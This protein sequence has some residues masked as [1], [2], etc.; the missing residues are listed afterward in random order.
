M[1]NLDPKD[2]PFLLSEEG[3]GAIDWDMLRQKYTGRNH[4][5]FN[6]QNYGGQRGAR[7]YNGWDIPDMLLDPSVKYRVFKGDEYLPEILDKGLITGGWNVGAGKPA[8]VFFG[9][10]TPLWSY[11]STPN[12]RYLIATLGT[13]WGD[14]HGNSPTN[15]ESET[16]KITRGN[17]N[18]DENDFGPG[19]IEI[20]KFTLPSHS[21]P[22]TPEIL[23]KLKEKIQFDGKMES[24]LGSGLADVLSDWS[25]GYK[26]TY[27]DTDSQFNAL[28]A[29]HNHVGTVPNHRLKKSWA[30]VD[31]T[32]Q[33]TLAEIDDI[34]KQ[35]EE[36]LKTR[37]GIDAS[38]DRTD[39]RR[40]I[41]KNQELLFDEMLDAYSSP[42]FFQSRIGFKDLIRQ[43]LM[44]MD[45]I[46]RQKVFVDLFTPE[47]RD[48][49]IDHAAWVDNSMAFLQKA[50]KDPN[51][52]ESLK[53]LI[54]KNNRWTSDGVLGALKMAEE[55]MPNFFD[56]AFWTGRSNSTAANRIPWN[57]T[58]SAEGMRLFLTAVD[59]AIKSGK[60]NPYSGSIL[61]NFLKADL[62]QITYGAKSNHWLGPGTTS[63]YTYFPS[64]EETSRLPFFPMS[65]QTVSTA[66]DSNSNFT[67]KEFFE[68]PT[69]KRYLKGPGGF[70]VYVG[71]HDDAKFTG[72]KATWYLK[73]N[74]GKELIWKDGQPT[75]IADMQWPAIGKEGAM[76][77]EALPVMKWTAPWT[78]YEDTTSFELMPELSINKLLPNE[79][80]YEI[81]GQQFRG[82]NFW[83]YI[84]SVISGGEQGADKY[85]ASFAGQA[86][87]VDR[88]D[89]PFIVAELKDGTQIAWHT[90][91]TRYFDNASEAFKKFAS[92]DEFKALEEKA[93]NTHGNGI[94]IK[95]NP[96]KK[97][98]PRTFQIPAGEIS[99]NQSKRPAVLFRI[100]LNSPEN[101]GGFEVLREWNNQP[102]EQGIK[103]IPTER[104]NPN[105]KRDALI[106]FAQETL[107]PL[108]KKRDEEAANGVALEIGNW[109]KDFKSPEDFADNVM[110]GMSFPFNE[111]LYGNAAI[112]APVIRKVPS[113]S[114][115]I[116]QTPGYTT[117]QNIIDE[118][119]KGNPNYGKLGSN[120][121]PQLEAIYDA[122]VRLD[123][124]INRYTRDFTRS[125][126]NN[127]NFRSSINKEALGAA[128]RYGPAAVM[129]AFAG[130]GIRDK[131][132][133][134]VPLWQAIP[135]QGVEMG[136]GYYAFKY[137]DRY[138][139]GVTMLGDATIEGHKRRMAE[140]DAIRAERQPEIARSVVGHMTNPIEKQK[141]DWKEVG[142]QEKA[143]ESQKRK[144]AYDAWLKENNIF[145]GDTI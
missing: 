144:D 58:S 81:N 106:R 75:R 85:N 4:I 50:Y 138:L 56:N 103:P 84:T 137:F 2:T 71:A 18:L 5:F 25:R 16:P 87:R 19:K 63:G 107:V 40:K 69:G 141:V 88:P 127:P 13:E 121:G 145:A 53:L 34:Q 39:L 24:V 93:K 67:N 100:G 95:I 22:K 27:G 109:A 28:L 124:G 78:T 125:Y 20:D 112:Q 35:I 139:G 52:P 99:L 131:V 72:P 48:A 26:T 114:Q 98:I 97:E 65:G 6:N 104:P 132:D 117:I 15:L 43:S 37:H 68:S 32:V 115:A 33:E 116:V 120:F 89:Y 54:Q 55:S 70:P 129:G 42:D 1:A 10:S 143:L 80:L 12:E 105:A 64:Y 136:A 79:K 94:L 44:E 29:L 3:G 90:S 60:T 59:D 66:E 82:F 101:P 45:D 41:S 46:N 108:I 74:F 47:V 86:R 49:L 57:G 14:R 77:S 51:T 31:D 9:Q 122:G 133:S 113:A 134:G 83:D 38:H 7:A 102:N 123:Q 73:S 118:S 128:G 11:A 61:H 92:T 30:R 126:V 62:G 111:I 119:T 76:H 23:A 142:K 135:A 140:E 8:G 36:S 96:S 21:N 91:G 110:A 17:I 130:M